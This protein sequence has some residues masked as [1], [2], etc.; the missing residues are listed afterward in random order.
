LI[1]GITAQQQQA[2]PGTPVT[3]SSGALEI[4][5]NANG[6][7]ERGLARPGD[8]LVKFRTD[9][10]VFSVM[11][12][13]TQGKEEAIPLPDLRLDGKD[14]LIAHSADQRRQ[15]V[16]KITRGTRHIGLRIAAVSGIATGR[17]GVRVAFYDIAG[18]RRF[19]AI[20]LDWMAEIGGGQNRIEFRWDH[21]DHPVAPG[22]LGG[23]AFYTAADDADED[24]ALLHIW[25]EEQMAHPKVAGAWTLERARAWMKNWQSMF[26]D[27]SQM[28]LEGKSLDELRAGIPY[29][30]RMQAKEIYLF[31][32]TWRT[33]GFWPGQNGHV[34]INREVFPRGEEDLRAFSDE[35]SA[36]GM[37]LKLHYVSGGIGKKD[38]RRIGTKP[39]RRLASWAKGTM[40]KPVN[41]DDPTIAIKPT[42]PVTWTGGDDKK[43]GR[44]DGLP[45]F[46]NFNVLRIDDELIEVGAFGKSADGGWLL[47]GCRRGAFGTIKAAHA[48]DSEATALVVPYNQNFVPDNDSSLLK[49]V[50]KEFAELLGRCHISHAEYDGA[51]IHCY[52]GRWGYRKFA[53]LVYQNLS[54]P[55]TTHDSSGGA[56]RANFEYRFHSTRQLMRGLCGFTHSGWNAPVQL[57][58]Q[59]RKASAMLDAHF[60][61][62]QGHYGGGLGLCRPEPLF[63]VSADGLKSFGLT[64]RMIHAVLDWKAV[65]RLLTA[66]QHSRLQATFQQPSAGMPDRNCHLQSP[67][68][69]EPRKTT[70]GYNIVPVRVLTRDK[71]DIAW[72]LGQEHGPVGPRQ[73]IK[74]GEPLELINPDHPQIP[75]F[76][77]RVLWGFAPDGPAVA[78]ATGD[79]TVSIEHSTA[80][81]FTAGNDGTNAKPQ[82]VKPNLRMMPAA[83]QEVRNQGSSIVTKEGDLLR[84]AADHPGEKEFWENRDLPSWS[85]ALD[86]SDRRG[87]GME[88]DGDDS[89]AALLVQIRGHGTRDYVVPIDFTG[90]RWIEIPN[91]EVAWAQGGWGWRMG[92]KHCNY[93]K[94]GAV[95]I[96][97]GYLPPGAKPTVTVGRLQ[98][99]AEIPVTLTNPV[100]TFGIRRVTM[101]GTLSS[102]EYLEYQG[103][104][105]AS[106]YDANWNLL[107]TLSISGS[108]EIPT[109]PLAVSLDA[110]S[111]GPKPWLEIQITTQGEPMVV[112]GP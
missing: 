91:G 93:E 40:A 32:Q 68:V 46:F 63:S 45:S 15:V 66:D 84:V 97:F 86:M 10:P 87:V 103:G 88:I 79:T 112:T 111:T 104:E 17:E 31:T 19:R 62:S 5:F 22:N 16:F 105:T 12:R 108:G 14:W 33:D 76:L 21:L 75:G 55:V 51:E 71:G 89:G 90:R 4:T 96:G 39:D 35:L 67:V 49:E 109:G 2:I 85:G 81:L 70:S 27:R 52:D 53:T 58:S 64:D 36:K 26:A 24:E 72:Q 34:H 25:V 57:D 50:A 80:D 47:T 18:N 107:R 60:F 100:L 94:V 28:I 73:F 65:S 30:E 3:I 95:Q 83:K 98:A 101:T 13:D 7:P 102:G 6:G 78:A 99:L 106:V 69:H 54:R 48:G 29:A 41:A 59:S 20:D 23:M 92:T 77:V 61:L 38:V 8:E 56:P 1:S 37:Q 9:L 82:G 44:P 110:A 43:L 42:S 11:V 74:T